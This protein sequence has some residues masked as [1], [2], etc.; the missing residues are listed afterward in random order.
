MTMIYLFFIDVFL[1]AIKGFSILTNTENLFGGNAGGG[2]LACFHGIRF[3]SATWIILGHTYFYTDTWKYLKYREYF[4]YFIMFKNMAEMLYSALIFFQLH[5]IHSQFAME[6]S[7]CHH[8]Y[9]LKFN[10]LFMCRNYH[11][12]PFKG[13]EGGM[14]A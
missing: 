4:Q 10:I 8:E 1:Q 3:L 13:E 12:F 7:E 9:F 11:C 2:S 6:V 14:P 5:A